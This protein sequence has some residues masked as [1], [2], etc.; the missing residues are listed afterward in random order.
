MSSD[1][2]ALLDQASQQVPD[3]DLAAVAWAEAARRRSRR[4]AFWA[5]GTLAAAL[6]LGVGIGWSALRDRAPTAP[7]A[8][9]ATGSGAA[10][11]ASSRTTGD[12]RVEP[13]WVDLPN[14]SEMD[15]LPRFSGDFLP[16]GRAEIDAADSIPLSQNPFAADE[17]IDA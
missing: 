9:S 8:G 14:P 17:R 11:T 2:T 1:I 15:S 6:V 12:P 7:P 13:A 4:R 10:T 5:S 16:Q 3:V